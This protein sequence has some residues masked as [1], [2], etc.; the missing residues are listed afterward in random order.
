MYLF[1]F[2][3]IFEFEPS[4]KSKLLVSLDHRLIPPIPSEFTLMID[5]K[6]SVE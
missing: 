1:R 5:K 3:Q 6:T 4:K 2:L